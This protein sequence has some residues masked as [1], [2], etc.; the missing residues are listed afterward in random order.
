MKLLALALLALVVAAAAQASYPRASIVV[1]SDGYAGVNITSP[2]TAYVPANFTLIGSPQYLT[3]SYVNGTPVVYAV[4]GNVV[5]VAPD[6]NG[7]ISVSYYTL[8]IIYKNNV[9]WFLNF[10]TPYYTVVRLPSG[11]TLDY[12]N[13]VPLSISSSDGTLYIELSPGSWLIGY[14]LPAPASGYMSAYSAI[15]GYLAATAAAAAAAAVFV[16]L[17]VRRRRRAQVKVERELDSRIIEFIRKNG[18]A[19]KESEIRQALVLPKTTAWRAIRRLEREGIV[20]VE[21]V[22]KENVVKLKE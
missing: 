1:Y 9:S 19:A 16:Y 21:K 20:T 12:I 14:L 15:W 13:R 3:V 17:L 4:R 6:E 5:E 11:S 8:S 2:V 18:G 22:G 7:T 10:T